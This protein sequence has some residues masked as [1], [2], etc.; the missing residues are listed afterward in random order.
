VEVFVAREP[1]FDVKDGVVGYEL[2]HRAGPSNRYSGLDPAVATGQLLSDNMLSYD[3]WHQLTG[4][5]RAWVNFPAEL[6]PSL[7]RC[8]T[9]PAG[10]GG[11]RS[12]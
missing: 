7:R 8:C 11:R 12:S 3:S 5:R 9:R 2:L 1:I 10:C 6:M 4:G